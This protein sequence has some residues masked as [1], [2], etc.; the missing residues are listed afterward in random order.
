MFKEI[1]FNKKQVPHW[2]IDGKGRGE[3]DLEYSTHNKTLA[4]RATESHYLKD[5]GVS[6]KQ[7]W[8]TLDTSEVDMLLAFLINSINSPEE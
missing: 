4:I 1:K 5:G 7:V 2:T 8:I 6:D 3:L